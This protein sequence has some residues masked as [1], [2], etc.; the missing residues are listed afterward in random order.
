[1]PMVTTTETQQT[2]PEVEKTVPVVR[3]SELKDFFGQNFID[4]MMTSPNN[5][6]VR[7]QIMK[8]TGQMPDPALDT[9]DKLKDWIE[10]N[11]AKPKSD[12]DKF[13]ESLSGGRPTTARPVFEL[14][15]KIAE[16]EL[17]TCWYSVRRHS[18]FVEDTS[19]D[20]ILDWINDGAGASDILN[21]ITSGVEENGGG[22][23]EWSQ[24]GPSYS[25]EEST[26]HEDF[27]IDLAH[28]V[29]QEK[30]RLMS[31]LAEVSP[32]HHQI[33]LDRETE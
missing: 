28:P 29:S 9:F 26:D 24:E 32:E 10:I 1:M 11:I 17:G 15:L 7:G 33:L 6:L 18:E 3:K 16:T 31:W 4:L 19:I 8:H 14:N 2:I 27:S 30:Q 12:L 21:N 22:D 13:K 23:I 25:R 20:D 5:T